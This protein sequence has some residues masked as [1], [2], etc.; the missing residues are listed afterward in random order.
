M[1][2]GFCISIMHFAILLPDPLLILPTL[3]QAVRNLPDSD[4]GGKLTSKPSGSSMHVRKRTCPVCPWAEPMGRRGARREPGP[5]LEDTG[6]MARVRTTP[7]LVPI[8]SRSLH[9]RRAVIRKHA[10]LCCRIMA[11]EPKRKRWD[12]DLIWFWNSNL[13]K[14][15]VIL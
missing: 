12:R 7:A 11:S 15:S 5:V 13:S 4:G 1:S 8:H 6:G 14:S 2:A 10:A 9:A 3:Q